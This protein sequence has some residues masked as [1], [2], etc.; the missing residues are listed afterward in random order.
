MMKISVEYCR[1]W[2]YKP[3]AVGLAAE[4]KESFNIEL[5]LIRGENGIFDVKYDG[6]L[7][8]SKDKRDRFPPLGEISFIL[9]LEPYCLTNE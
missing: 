2:N 4:L 8:I 9:K 3:M 7:I 1:M 6:R 5:E